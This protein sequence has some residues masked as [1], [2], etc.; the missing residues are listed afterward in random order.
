MVDA[1]LARR[2]SPTAHLNP[3]GGKNDLEAL[4]VVLYSD[5]DPGQISVA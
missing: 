4:P 1:Y 5:P 2:S 3:H